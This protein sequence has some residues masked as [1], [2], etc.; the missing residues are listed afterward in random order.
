[1]GT[2]HVFENPYLGPRRGGE[3][4]IYRH[5]YDPRGSWALL[6]NFSGRYPPR[7]PF[8]Y[9]HLCG[10]LPK[11]GDFGRLSLNDFKGKCSIFGRNSLGGCI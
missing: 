3:T 6:N 8:I 11:S 10:F 1:M 4:H 9:G 5:I 2:M 7:V